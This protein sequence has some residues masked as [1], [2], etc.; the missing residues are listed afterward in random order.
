MNLFEETK[1]K[2]VTPVTDKLQ[3]KKKE[4]LLQKVEPTKEKPKKEVQSEKDLILEKLKHIESIR[5]ENSLVLA[6]AAKRKGNEIEFEKH[7]ATYLEKKSYT[8][9]I[10]ESL[11]QSYTKLSGINCFYNRVTEKLHFLK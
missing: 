8:I 3:Q 6:V 1:P 7:Y 4:P 10:I 5:N 2:K 9:H 11:C